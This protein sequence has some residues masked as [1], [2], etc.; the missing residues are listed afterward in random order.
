MSRQYL[1]LFGSNIEPYTNFEK[2]DER[3][4]NNRHLRIV[5]VSQLYETPAIGET[6]AVD[7]VRASYVNAAFL[8][9]SELA[10]DEL[11]KELRT[12]EAAL[13]R[14]RTENKFA[15]RPVDL[16]ALAYREGGTVTD[17]DAD[18]WSHM[19]VV[20]PAADIAA[21][22]RVGLQNKRL[23][24]LAKYIDSRIGEFRRNK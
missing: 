4:R 13:G 8:I 9:D 11:K 19:H 2:A 22:W 20:L 10:E 16:D 24:E 23:S 14:M 17:L 15:E 6:G 12:I 18:A 3:L 1:L 7:P 5:D 21:E